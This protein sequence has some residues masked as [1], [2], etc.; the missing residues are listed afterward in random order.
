MV[1]WRMESIS[2]EVFTNCALALV[3]F[4]SS[5][6]RDPI[7]GAYI[8]TVWFASDHPISLSV[9]DCPNAETT[10][11]ESSFPR[12][13][14]TFINLAETHVDAL[15]IVRES[16]CSGGELEGWTVTDLTETLAGAGDISGYDSDMLA[17]PGLL[18]ILDKLVG[19]RATIFASGSRTCAKKSS[20]TKQIVDMRKE[21][22][23]QRNV[24]DYFG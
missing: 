16:F 7:L 3:D 23:R 21:E 14:N 13:S 18:G 9:L 15:R 5:T 20:F 10:L 22:S 12:K 19:V 4:L 17:D 1:H 24:V 8:K 11:D 6:L 2:P